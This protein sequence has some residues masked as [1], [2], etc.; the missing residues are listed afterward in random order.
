AS[1]VVRDSIAERE[2]VN[3]RLTLSEAGPTVS[4]TVR[5]TVL[6]ESVTVSVA[7]PTDST[8]VREPV[9]T[10]VTEALDV[11]DSVTVREPVN[12]RATA[13]VVVKDS[14]A[15]RVAA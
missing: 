6:V 12:T 8:T 10:R 7:G 15:V 1:L 3:T 11:L 9:N 5:L 4:V 14:V 2:P 13:S